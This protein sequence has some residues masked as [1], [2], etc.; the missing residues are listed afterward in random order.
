MTFAAS[1]TQSFDVTM[2]PE[3]LF[4]HRS[5]LIAPNSFIWLYCSVN[6]SDPR[7]D[8]IWAKNSIQ[9]IENIP[10]ILF[11]NSTTE[12]STVKILIVNNFTDTDDGMYQCTARNGKEVAVG[13]PIQLTG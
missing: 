9:I 10:H 11:M 3:V 8:I 1:Y 6:F 12:R 4:D 13:T 7:L 5:H 2:L